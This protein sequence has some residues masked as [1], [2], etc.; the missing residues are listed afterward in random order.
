MTRR[1]MMVATMAVVFGLGMLAGV[2]LALPEG[3]AGQARR[4]L[5]QAGQARAE[6]VFAAHWEMAARGGEIAPPV[7]VCTACIQA[8]AG[9]GQDRAGAKAQCAAACGLE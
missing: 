4:A 8:A 2:G 9:R 1:A 3:Q 7:S 5:R 6:A